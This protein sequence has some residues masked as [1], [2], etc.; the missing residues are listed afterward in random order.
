MDSAKS[1]LESFHAS[2]G[3]EAWITEVFIIVFLTL[4]VNFIQKRLLARLAR[5]LGTTRNPWDDAVIESLQKPLT[6]LIWIVGLAFAIQ[7]IQ[8]AEQAAIFAAVRPIRDVGVIAT[9]AW[10]LV[11]FIK[12]AEHNILEGKEER[13]EEYDR[14][15]ADAVAKLFRLSVIITA[16]LVALQT[17]G[18]SVS[19]VLAFGGIGGI[20]IGFAAKDLLA[21]FFGGLMIYLDRP[22]T[23]GDWVRSPDR[24][25]EGTVE[26]IGWRLTMIRTFDSRHLYIPNA[27]FTSIAVQNPSRMQNRRIYETIGIRY[28]D[29]AKMDAIVGDVTAMLKAHPEIDADKTLM[30]NF[31]AFAAS[32]LDFFV[33]CMTKTTV[34]A[35]YHAVKQDVL[36]K[37]LEIID[38]YGAE[39]A[40]PTSTIHIPEGIASPGGPGMN[41]AAP[42]AAA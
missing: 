40:F 41:A 38:G 17:L 35:E 32:S 42:Q 13:G 25:I 11:R 33:Y 22:F 14:A 28:D 19:G 15:T 10:F 12:R 30:V 27:T 3:L 2:L 21:N 9:L 20:A 8:E 4:V 29:A 36:L 5:K 37:I 39:V 16:V 24:D 23:I 1:I 7:V 18:Y 31:N 34:W 6:A 26:K